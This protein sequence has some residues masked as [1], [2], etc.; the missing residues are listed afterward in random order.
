MSP[1]KC[2]FRCRCIRACKETTKYA[3]I[4][5]VTCI[6]VTPYVHSGVLSLSEAFCCIGFPKWMISKTRVNMTKPLSGPSWKA[7]SITFGTSSPTF[8]ARVDTSWSLCAM[9]SRR[10]KQACTQVG[11]RNANVVILPIF[12]SLAAPEVVKIGVHWNGKV[13]IFVTCSTEIVILI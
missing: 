5:L 7:S 10:W 9:L 11:Q 6:P 1:V 8:P 13:E 12:P 3:W 2:C 4:W